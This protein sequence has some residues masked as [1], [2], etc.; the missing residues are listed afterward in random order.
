MGVDGRGHLSPPSCHGD[1]SALRQRGRRRSPTGLLRRPPGSPATEVDRH[2]DLIKG[3]EV[4]VPAQAIHANA[5]MWLPLKNE[6]PHSGRGE[7]NP[8]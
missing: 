5:P 1:S 4:G 8:A 3:S 6:Q 2:S 7:L